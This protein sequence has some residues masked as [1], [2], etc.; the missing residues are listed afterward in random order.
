MKNAHD[1]L[2]AQFGTATLDEL[3]GKRSSEDRA[4]AFDRVERGMLLGQIPSNI[5]LVETDDFWGDP[6]FIGAPS[7][8][9]SQLIPNQQ[10]IRSEAQRL[11]SAAEVALEE[12]Y[13]PP[14][15]QQRAEPESDAEQAWSGFAQRHPALAR[16]RSAAE[17]AA[18]QLADSGARF[19]SMSEFYD[20][21]ATRLS[22]EDE[23][24][25]VG[26]DTNRS[27]AVA[28]P[29]PTAVQ[30]DMASELAESQRR[31]GWH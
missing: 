27:G 29:K 7:R 21:L 22:N 14:A 13:E 24:R 31:A 10:R 28:R 20:A 6:E 3:A 17:A 9:K 2:A 25:A 4:T 16:D 26:F 11:R 23:G 19:S 12:G 15:S 8:E 1:E 5:D 18:T 30:S